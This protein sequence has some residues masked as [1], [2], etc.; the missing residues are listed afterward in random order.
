MSIPT[1]KIG[2]IGVGNISPAYIKGCRAFDILDAA[3][4]QFRMRGVRTEIDLAYDWEQE[5]PGGPRP[6]VAITGTDGKTTTTM[7]VA[8]L[9][10]A[11]GLRTVAVGNTEVPVVANAS[12][13]S[14]SASLSAIA[15]R[16]MK[17]TVSN[18]R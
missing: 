15:P 9:L 6:M 1:F 13:S 14:S 10:T 17:L 2:I 5:R 8:S 4:A 3:L 7:L 11:A 16:R 18:P 12:T